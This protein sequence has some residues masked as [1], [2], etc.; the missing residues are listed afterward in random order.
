MGK[1]A[2]KPLAQAAGG[3]AVGA[4]ASAAEQLHRTGTIDAESTILAAGAGATGA[5]GSHRLN[6]PQTSPQ[7][8][9]TT[10]A[11][12][13]ASGQR[14]TPNTQPIGQTYEGNVLY[15]APPRAVPTGTKAPIGNG[16]EVDVYFAPEPQAVLG[17]TP[18]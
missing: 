5:L 13:V 7:Q 17:K 10:Q 15:E 1:V 8:T 4:G 14:V 6:T 18:E 3:A 12:P 11:T 16:T 9:P 2:A